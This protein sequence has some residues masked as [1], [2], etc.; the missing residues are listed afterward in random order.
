MFSS[1]DSI[2][3]HFPG[4]SMDKES[5]CQSRRRRFDP[6]VGKIPWRRNWQYPCLKNPKDRGTWWATVHG[7]AKESNMTEWAQFITKARKAK[8]PFT[9]LGGSDGKMSVYNV[10]DLGSISGSGR[11]PGERNGNP[12]Q[13]VL[14]PRKSH[15]RGGAWCRLLSTG[16]QKVRHGW[17]TSL[18]FRVQDN[19]R[20]LSCP[21]FGIILSLSTSILY[22]CHITYNFPNVSS[23][24]YHQNC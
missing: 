9:G 1:N 3:P 11:Y 16:W 5:D 7:I 15:G 14:L 20:F 6:W 8:M 19:W 24:F 4:G 23:C 12:L 18:H 17:V 21:P 2:L 22:T 10:G 13:P